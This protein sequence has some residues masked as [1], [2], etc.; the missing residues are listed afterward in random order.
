[1]KRRTFLKS[2]AL[3]SFAG[4]MPVPALLSQPV[5]LHPYAQPDLL[6]LLDDADAV[7]SIG[8]A[9]LASQ[10]EKKDTS[11]LLNSLKQRISSVSTNTTDEAVRHSIKR[12]FTAGE[13]RRLNG[14]ILAETEA[15]QC[16]LFSLIRT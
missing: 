3:S 7:A 5:S 16:A 6:L 14:W 9:Y 12:D 1:M 8:S 15:M 10:P 13:T 4:L 2:T 11:S